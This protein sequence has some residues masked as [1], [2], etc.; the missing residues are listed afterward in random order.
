M[1][2]PL[3]SSSRTPESHTGMVTIMY[4]SLRVPASSLVS[5]PLWG[6]RHWDSLSKGLEGN[7]KSGTCVR[8]HSCSPSGWAASWLGNLRASLGLSFFP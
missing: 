8:L 3:C 5:N 1:A 6:H 2:R 4:L 7:G